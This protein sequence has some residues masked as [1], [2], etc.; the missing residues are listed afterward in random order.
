MSEHDSLPVQPEDSSGPV[1]GV[2]DG[3]V[4]DGS[5]ASIDMLAAALRRDSAD[6]E[7]YVQVLTGSLADA[8]PQGAV[9]VERKRSVG[10]RLSGREGKV[11]KLEVSLDDRRLIL[12]LTHGRPQG[13]VATVVRGVVLSRQPVGLDVWATELAT[14]VSVR[15][16]S[17]ARA[18][19]ALEKLVLGG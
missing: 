9:T 8:L 18:R 13:E 5:G 16:Q 6:L 4:V 15:A 2:V 19:A 7:I 10:D 17:D 12:T 3:P 11:E 14:A 1:D